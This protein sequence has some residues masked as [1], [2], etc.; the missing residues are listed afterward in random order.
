MKRRLAAREQSCPAATTNTCS[1]PFFVALS[2]SRNSRKILRPPLASS[3]APTFFPSAKNRRRSSRLGG[4]YLRSVSPVPRYSPTHVPAQFLAPALALSASS[5][6][7]KSALVH[8]GEY[9]RKTGV[10]SAVSATKGSTLSAILRG[11][12]RDPLTPRLCHRLSFVSLVHRTFQ[13]LA[14]SA[15]RTSFLTERLLSIATPLKTRPT[16]FIAAADASLEAIAKS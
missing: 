3:L 12:R 8:T 11:S 7:A 14:T 15:T 10:I 1:S 9:E 5:R 13:A 6:F 16:L 4:S 2:R